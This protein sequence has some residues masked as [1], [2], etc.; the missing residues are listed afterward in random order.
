MEEQPDGKDAASDGRFAFWAA[1][2]L[3]SHSPSPGQSRTK[4]VLL[5][6]RY[7][8]EQNS[9]CCSFL[10]SPGPRLRAAGPPPS[11][12]GGL[13]RLPGACPACGPLPGASPV[14]A[15][16]PLA[17]PPAPSRVRAAFAVLP[18]APPGRRRAGAP[19]RCGPTVPPADSAAKIRHAA[20][21]K[22][23]DSRYT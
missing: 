13:A 8:T 21:D 1:L 5:F 10:A 7:A 22:A 2:R 15:P 18:A 6:N 4:K 23:R 3:G 19:R 11:C 16:G 12:A 17:V 20:L 9:F 14:G